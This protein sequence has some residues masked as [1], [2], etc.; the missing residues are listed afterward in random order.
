MRLVI[1][2]PF[3]ETRGGM[4]RVVLKIAQQFKAK[5]HCYSYDPERTF[6]EFRA[7]DIE[8]AKPG[9]I[10]KLPLGKRLTTAIEAGNH[11]YNVKL[12]DYDLINAHQ[13]PSES[14]PEQQFAG[15]MVL[16]FAKS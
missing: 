7:L 15:I 9:N 12:K 10:S 14:D 11:F 4:E 2:T 13:T 3:L 16:L 8:T 5:I 6:P 1:A